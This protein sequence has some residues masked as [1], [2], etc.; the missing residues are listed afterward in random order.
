M[1]SETN[2]GLLSLLTLICSNPT[3]L[4]MRKGISASNSRWYYSMKIVLE[5]KL[6]SLCTKLMILILSLQLEKIDIK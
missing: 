6:L 4:S 5:R 3:I 1:V 2:M